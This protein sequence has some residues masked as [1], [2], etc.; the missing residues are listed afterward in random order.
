MDYNLRN[1]KHGLSNTLIRRVWVNIKQRCFNKNNKKYPIYG[2]RGI[3]V[4]KLWVDDFMAFYDYVIALPNYDEKRLG[5][6][7]GLTIDR[8]NNDGN[9]EP[10]NL[11]WTTQHIQTINQRVRITNISGYTGV[12]FRKSS[13]KYVSRIRVNDISYYLGYFENLSEAVKARNQYI[14]DHN[15]SEYPL[16]YKVKEIYQ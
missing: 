11:R 15:L 14:I 12:S 9:Y 7:G 6:K 16:Q 10:G 4:Y 2:A 1:F 13:K 5:R 8:I 3:S